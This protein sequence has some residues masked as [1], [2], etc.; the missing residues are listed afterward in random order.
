MRAQS[1]KSKRSI[2]GVHPGVAMMQKWIE[3]LKGKTRPSLGEWIAFEEKEGPR[4]ETDRR[5][6]LKSKHKLGTNSAWRIAERSDGRGG[7]EDSDKGYLGAA[8]K[9]VEGQY[10][11][12]NEAPRPI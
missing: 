3:E 1:R 11:G 6:G 5:D 2:C 8:A 12:R 4:S 7:N 9:Y 10:T